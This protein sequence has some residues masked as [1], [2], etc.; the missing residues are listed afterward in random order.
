MG[1]SK[2]KI[3]NWTKYNRALYHRGKVTFGIDHSAVKSWKC[4]E[5]H[6]KQGRGFQYSD[7]AIETALTIKGIFSVPLRALQGFIDSIFKLMDVPL[8]SPDLINTVYPY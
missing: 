7:T 4:T 2:A 3:T 8:T 5:H 1:K 6:G